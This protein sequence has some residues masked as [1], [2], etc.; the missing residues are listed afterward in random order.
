MSSFLLQLMLILLT[1]CR[2]AKT[3]SD[4]QSADL[5]LLNGANYAK[6]VNKVSL[7]RFRM[8][9][10]SA[11]FKDRYIEAAEMLTHSHGAEGKHGHEALAFTTWIDFGLAVRTSRGDCE[12]TE[13]QEACF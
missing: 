6:W 7:P 1:G 10:T 2:D 4:Y 3:I 12:S 8:V 11:A 13:P 5:I 9:N